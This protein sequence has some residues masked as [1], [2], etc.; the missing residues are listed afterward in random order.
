M[1][2]I[3]KLI[4]FLFRALLSFVEKLSR[5]YTEFP[6][7]FSP[8]FLF[9]PPYPHSPIINILISVVHVLQLVN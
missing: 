9:F 4:D 1:L 2:G 6:Q 5:K 8:P 3:F 7:T